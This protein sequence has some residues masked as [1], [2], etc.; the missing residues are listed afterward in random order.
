MS[1][2]LE[3][4]IEIIVKVADP[5]QIILFGSR[6]RGDAKQDSDYDLL[7][8]KNDVKRTHKL[9]QEIYLNFR[10]IGAPVDVIVADSQKYHSLKDDPYLVYS[11]AAKEGRIVYERH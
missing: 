9:A 2:P 1:N 4:A 6:A 8:L 5:D 3:R 7:V 10:N 11:D